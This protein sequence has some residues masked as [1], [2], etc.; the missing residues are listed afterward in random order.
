MSWFYNI[1]TELQK[2]EAYMKID[3]LIAI[4]MLLLQQ[5]KISASTL[6]EKLGV[7]VRTIYRDVETLSLAGIPI[8]TY[9]GVNG[10]IA[11]LEEYKVDKH[12]FTK[13]DITVLVNSLASIPSGLSNTA[14]KNTV[15]KLQSFLPD[16][17]ISA[18]KIMIDPTPWGE[19]SK[20]SVDLLQIQDALTNNYVVCFNYTRY[21]GTQTTRTVEPGR[22]ILKG[23]AWYLQGYC[24]LRKDFRIFKLSRIDSLIVLNET[25]IPKKLPDVEINDMQPTHEQT[26]SIEIQLKIKPVLKAMLEDI[27][28]P[29]NISVLPSGD[30]LANMMFDESEW[31]YNYLLGFGENCECLSPAHVRE[32]LSKKITV[33]QALYN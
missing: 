30:F 1:F 15:A 17:D 2:L 20:T 23:F 25:F 12:L 27:C 4:I 8:V 24:T 29:G 33:M 7:T 32:K 19:T 31:A 13:E 14:Q 11:I 28:G 22:L 21:D 26:P 3:R 18:G 10:G 6:S 5:D 16:I 9:P